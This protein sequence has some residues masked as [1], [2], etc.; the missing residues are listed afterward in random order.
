MVV[1]FD[2]IIVTLQRSL[3]HLVKPGAR[4]Q[5]ELVIDISFR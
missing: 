3:V 5:E 2:G 4:F 1:I